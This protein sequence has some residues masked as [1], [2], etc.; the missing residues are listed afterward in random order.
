MD[1]STPN[2]RFDEK[3]HKYELDGKPMMGVT[4]VLNSTLAK[5]ALIGWAAKMT[6]EWIR[7]NC[8][9]HVFEDGSSHHDSHFA[10]TE[11]DLQEAVKAHTKKKEAAG[12]S[13]KDT[14]ALIE[15]YVGG[16]IEDFMGVPQPTAEDNDSLQA[17]VQWALSSKV[18]FLKSEERMY[19][20]EWWTAGTADLILEMDGKR[21]IGDVKTQAKLWDNTPHVQCAAYA[22]MYKE[23][24][25]G[26][27]DGTI[28]IVIPRDNPTVETHLRYNL[29]GDIK[30]FEA[31]L[32][33]YKT[34][35]I[36]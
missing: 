29:E 27:I 32:L 2:F 16:C 4:T 15:N 28:V 10:V 26:D 5:P 11:S 36:K 1:T 23:M 30:A 17:F 31:A 18:T 24:G 9:W 35:P 22:K 7:E 19:S 25:H 21:Y 12:T 6:A 8:K 3:G 20:K 34:I 33:L 13:G 14:H